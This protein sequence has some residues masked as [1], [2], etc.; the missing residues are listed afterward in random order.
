[1]SA[2][3]GG[4]APLKRIFSVTT[5]AT[6][7][8]GEPDF[9]NGDVTWLTPEDLSARDGHVV[10]DSVRKITRAGYT[11]CGTTKVPAGSVILSTRA[12][13][14]YAALCVVEV[15]FNQGCKALVPRGD[16]NSRYWLYALGSAREGLRSHGRG[17]TYDELGTQQLKDYEVFWPDHC[18]Q[19]AIATYLDTETVRIDAL[20]DRKQ[21]FIDLL[22]AKRSAFITHA[23]T[24]GLDP[25]AETK[26]WP[27]VV[28]ECVPAHWLLRRAK[29]I[30][31]ERDV[32]SV[33]GSEELLS[34]SHITGVTRR[35]EKQVYMFMA[36]TNE[37]YK[38][39]RAGDVAINTM[40]AYQGAAGVAPCDGI[41]S[42]SYN[43]YSFSTA[44]DVRYYDLLLR[45]RPLVAEFD[46]RSTGIW[47]SRLRLYPSEFL[48]I[49][50]PVPPLGEQRAIVAAVTEQVDAM[51]RLADKTRRSIDL[52]HE[53]R[54]ALI[55]AAVA[56]QIDIPGPETREEVA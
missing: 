17:S 27:L 21:H 36:E 50:L 55:S 44:V 53:Y 56:G 35:S 40:W 12:P 26:A 38:T 30:L 45:S 24:K 34:V 41:V 43:V 13:I 48:D 37:G 9:W 1:V 54:T 39:C 22:L 25:E 10:A 42:P 47:K 11:S 14:G 51:D 8:S 7:R 3:R 6:P 33:D 23:V 20:I 46:S 2:K 15:C 31:R 19:D 52:L 29:F 49:T 16:E 28:E 4:S 5:G 18:T 32:R